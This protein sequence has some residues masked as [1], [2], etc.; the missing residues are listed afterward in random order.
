MVEYPNGD[1]GL[2]NIDITSQKKN[3]VPFIP[4][5]DF[6]NPIPVSKNPPVDP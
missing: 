2:G 6:N 1:V 4:Y 3:K 5:P